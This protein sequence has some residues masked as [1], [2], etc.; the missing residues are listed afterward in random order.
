MGHASYSPMTNNNNTI[1]ELHHRVTKKKIFYTCPLNQRC[2][3]IKELKMES[4]FHLM[5]I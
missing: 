3:K 5:K 4:T 2:F 1:I